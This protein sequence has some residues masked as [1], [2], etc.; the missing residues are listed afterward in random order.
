MC[1]HP[2]PPHPPRLTGVNC[3]CI[4][5]GQVNPQYKKT[6]VVLIHQKWPT[7]TTTLLF[8][9]YFNLVG[10]VCLL[11]LVNDNN[12]NKLCLAIFLISIFFSMQLSSA[13]HLLHPNTVM[14]HQVSASTTLH[15]EH[16]VNILA[17]EAIE[18]TGQK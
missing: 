10:P 8:F 3:D 1:P 15:T 18:S 17:K 6:I 4:K 2:L 9:S 5:I 12:K 7:W 16:F 11:F 14:S 13:A